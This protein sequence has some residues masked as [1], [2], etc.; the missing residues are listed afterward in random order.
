[1]MAVLSEAGPMGEVEDL[2]SVGF[3]MEDMEVS[4][5]KHKAYKAKGHHVPKAK[6]HHVPKAKGYKGK[7]HKG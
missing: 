4:E 1:M 5:H 2:E 7:G 6:G 3:D